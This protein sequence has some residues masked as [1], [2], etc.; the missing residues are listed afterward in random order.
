MDGPRHPHD[1]TLPGHHHR[2]LPAWSTLLVG[3]V[4]PDDVGCQS[5]RLQV[6]FNDT[7]RSWSDSAPHLHRESDE[8]FVALDGEIV[9]TVGDERVTIGPGEFC[10]F[11]AGVVH[12]VVETHPPMRSLMIRAPAVADK[13]YEPEAR[14]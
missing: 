14:A 10:F 12:N 5:D 1:L 3:P 8:L 6:W 2:P 11:P 9:V 7:D 4:P 13:V